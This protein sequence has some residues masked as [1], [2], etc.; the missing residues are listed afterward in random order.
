MYKILSTCKLIKWKILYLRQKFSLI[1][2][3]S[4]GPTVEKESKNVQM[5]MKYWSILS[6]P[7]CPLQI[8]QMAKWDSR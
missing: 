4:P 1:K 8:I 6:M 3:F 2:S 5:T 7:N